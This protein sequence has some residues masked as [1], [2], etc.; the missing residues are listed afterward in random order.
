MNLFNYDQPTRKTNKDLVKEVNSKQYAKYN[1]LCRERNNEY[2]GVGKNEQVICKNP[3]KTADFA[4]RVIGED[5]ITMREHAYIF[6]LSASLE[7]RAYMEI[8][9]GGYSSSVADL[10]LAMTFLLMNCAVSAILVHNHP[11][12]GLKFSPQ[13]L[14]LNRDLRHACKYMKIDLIDS[15]IITEDFYYSEAESEGSHSSILG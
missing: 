15:M 4:R 2:N 14:N 5:Q 11:A 10:R 12:G 1:V 7:V 3:K 6:A 9:N 8:G 13:D